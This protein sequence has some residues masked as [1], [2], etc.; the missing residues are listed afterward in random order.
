MAQASAEKIDRAKSDRYIDSSLQSLQDEIAEIQQIL[1]KAL[2]SN[3]DDLDTAPPF[4]TAAAGK[5]ASKLDEIAGALIMLNMAEPAKL[6]AHLKLA[7]LKL[8]NNPALADVKQRQAVFEAG[9]FLSLYIDFVRSLR[10]NAGDEMPL[11][12]S[13][14]F[15][16]LASAGLAPFVDESEIAGIAI[17]LRLAPERTGLFDEA[18][19]APATSAPPDYNPEHKKNLNQREA[20]ANNQATYRR[21]R[22]MY[23]VALIGLLRGSSSNE[24]LTLVDHVA[25]RS[26]ELVDEPML[27]AAW[28]S[29]SMLVTQFTQGNLELT[30]QRK[31]FFAR[32][33]RWLREMSKG[34]FIEFHDPENLKAIRELATLLILAG[35]QEYALIKF[36]DFFSI[37]VVK[38]T[39]EQIVAQ[40]RSVESGLRES[41]MAM[42][43]SIS[44]LLDGLKQRLSVMSESELCEQSDVSYLT[45]TMQAIAAVLKFCNFTKPALVLES[46][47]EQVKS[48]TVEM[49]TEQVLLQVANSILSIENALL[50]YSMNSAVGQSE[51]DASLSLEDGM[52]AQAHQNLFKEMQANISLSIRALNSYVESEYDREHIA[53]VG[54]SLINAIGGFQMVGLVDAANLAE[55]CATRIN[56]EYDSEESGDTARLEKIADCLVSIEYVLHEL[57]AGG[58]LDGAM[59]QLIAENM[60][61]L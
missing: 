40:R 25:S 4:E 29:I 34:E 11:I 57:A 37:D 10:A 51:H 1:A 16:K 31:H 21:L 30:P 6:V 23:Q 59:Q 47:A 56:E 39:D 45:S 3:W 44:E 19:A 43:E 14:F 41:L 35:H 49:P 24:Q 9:Y 60:A 54:N 13:P 26:A 17:N 22:K 12:L 61:S 5:I 8:G 46:T 33:D 48:W 7:V 42:S 15:Y 50:C 32:F 2:D 58:K 53:N 28:A 36:H 55:K 38:W 52:I 27:Q 18:P 20:I